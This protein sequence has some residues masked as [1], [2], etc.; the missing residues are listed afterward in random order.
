MIFA[1]VSHVIM[2]FLHP[3]KK[4]TWNLKVGAP[5]KKSRNPSKKHTKHT[6]F[7]LFHVDNSTGFPGFLAAALSAQQELA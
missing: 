6:M 7:Q 3:R 4:L 2:L 5:G 1:T